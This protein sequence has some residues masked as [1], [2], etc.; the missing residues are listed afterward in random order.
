MLKPTE[1]NQRNRVA[2]LNGILDNIDS[3]SLNKADAIQS[4]IRLNN[5]LARKREQKPAYSRYR[6][7]LDATLEA[8]LRPHF[9]SSSA[10]PSP[11]VKQ[12]ALD[13]DAARRGT[14]ADAAERLLI[15]FWATRSDRI[16]RTVYEAL[17]THRYL[18]VPTDDRYGSAG[19]VADEIDAMADIYSELDP[20]DSERWS[21]L[22]AL[23]T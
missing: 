7:T 6:P 13:L 1:I 8:Y 23:A 9:E 15:V 11:T 19:S 22:A 12:I 5:H 21:Y 3:D 20:S 10:S 2:Q 16:R 18:Q 17:L 4:L 14:N